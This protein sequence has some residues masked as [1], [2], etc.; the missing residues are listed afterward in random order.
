MGN[1][2]HQALPAWY[3]HARINL[4]ASCTENCPNI[5]LELMASGRPALVS[6]R[7]PMPEFGGQTVTYFDPENVGQLVER[8]LGLLSDPVR[9]N[10]L[11]A[12]AL[13]RVSAMSWEKTASLTWSAMLEVGGPGA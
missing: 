9:G 4:F 8:W 11:A 1:L 10:W 6:G 5:L 13:E 3:Q 2:P 12:A 7:G